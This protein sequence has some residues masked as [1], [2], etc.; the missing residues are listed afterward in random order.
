M[1]SSVEDFKSPNGHNFIADYNYYVMP[2]DVF[3]AVKILCHTASVCFAQTAGS[4]DARGR[5]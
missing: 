1:K 5:P 2:A 4:C 3:D